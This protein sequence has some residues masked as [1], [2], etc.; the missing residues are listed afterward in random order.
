MKKTVCDIDVRGKRVL[1]RVDFNIP[2][3]PKSGQISNDI[4]IRASLPTIRY[5]LEQGAKVILCSHLGRPDG[6][7]VESL[8]LAPVAKRLSELLGQ[9]V[10]SL[11]EVIGPAVSKRVRAIKRGEVVLLENIRFHPGE[12]KNDPALSQ[13]LAKLADVFVNDGFSVSHRAHASTVGVARLLPAVAG[14]LMERE[15][16][17]LSQVLTNP[18][19]PFAT[20]LGGAK[21]ADKTGILQNLLGKIDKL[22]IGGGMSATFLKA[23]GLGVGR[24]AVEENRLELA[25][26]IMAR[27]QT[28]NVVLTLPDDVVV[29]LNPADPSGA[30]IVTVAEIPSQSYIVDVGPWTIEHFLQ[31]LS[32]CRTVLWNGPLGIF[33]VPRF[34]EG[35]RAIAQALAES[36]ATTVVGGG[37]TAEAVEEMGLAEKLTHVST[38]GGASLEFLEGRS[39]PGIAALLEK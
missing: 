22:L 38:G 13:E 1:V 39:L 34:A 36:G 21:V 31:E 10:V 29:A 18:A 26:Q 35:T 32:G 15:I 24:S 5:L 19:R 9:Q 7:V 25:R 3:D 16:A 8:R 20:I 12:E 28:D 37:S 33:E 6:K 23:T 27:S 30:S 2:L 4:R 11:P 14:F 17:A